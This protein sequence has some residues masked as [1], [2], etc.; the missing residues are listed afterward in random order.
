MRGMSRSESGSITPLGHIA[1][2]SS[3]WVDIQTEARGIRHE[4]NGE[5]S[6]SE[7]ML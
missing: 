2:S 7:D 5:S 1:S 3:H 6:R 4:R